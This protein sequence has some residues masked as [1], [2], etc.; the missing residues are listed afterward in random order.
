[1][2]LWVENIRKNEKVNEEDCPKIYIL[3]IKN[4][5]FKLWIA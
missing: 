5:I 4:L 1:M 3:Y 2:K